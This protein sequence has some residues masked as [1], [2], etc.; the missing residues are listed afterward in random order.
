[1]AHLDMA[2][3]G[4]STARAVHSRGEAFWRTT[5]SETKKKRVGEHQDLLPYMD[6]VMVKVKKRQDGLATCA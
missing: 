6:M 1:V 5:T 2:G 3:H 4:G